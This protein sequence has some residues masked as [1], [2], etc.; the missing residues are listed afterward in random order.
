M[1]KLPPAGCCPPN[2]TISIS[3]AEGAGTRSGNTSANAEMIEPAMRLMVEV[4]AFT[5]AGSRGLT[6]LPSGKCNEIGRKQPA[7][8]GIAGSVSARIAKHAAASEPDG[9]QF[10]GPRT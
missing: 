3:P 4:R 8:V 9:T 1:T 2:A 7:L 6:R 10:I 5:G